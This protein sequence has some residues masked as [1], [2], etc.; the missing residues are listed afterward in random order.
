MRPHVF[1]SNCGNTLKNPLGFT[2]IE[3]LVVI[4]II[5]LLAAML[6]PVFAR[7]RETARRTTCLSNLRQIGLAF[8]M[9]VDDHGGLYPNTGNPYLWMGRY[10]RWPLESYLAC[11]GDRDPEDPDNPLVSEEK[12]P[13]ILI[14]PS[15]LSAPK[16][17]DSTSYG[18]SAA[19]Y[20]TPRQINRM[21]VEDLWQYDDFPCISQSEGEV[22]FPAQKILIAEWLTNHEEK[23]LG[24]WDWYGARNYLFADGHVR[25]LPAAKI[26]PSVTGLPDPNLTVDGIR[27]RDLQ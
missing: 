26:L 13:H 21:T 15:D 20:H 24:W 6:F 4:A 8:Q 5:A 22:A 27:G 25:Y 12:G 16:K 18:Y 3:L 10:W 1:R 17:W 19:F 9:Y 14:C 2:L 7:A 11:V 23:K